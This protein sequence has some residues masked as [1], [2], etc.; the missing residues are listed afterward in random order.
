MK[1]HHVI[2]RT[3]ITLLR[4]QISDARRGVPVL[5]I[6]WQTLSY[7]AIW[8]C[9][10]LCFKGIRFALPSTICQI[11]VL[12]CCDSVIF[13]VVCMFICSI[14][15]HV[16]KHTLEVTIV[17][18]CVYV[19]VL[20]NTSGSCGYLYIYI[21]RVTILIIRYFIVSRERS[22]VSFN[23]VRVTRSLDFYV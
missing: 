9:T 23:W 18:L 14:Y 10:W 11:G 19:E 20:F 2:H 1:I 16:I 22:Y 7:N 21:F 8:G 13:F 4:Y 3:G 17:L 12:N 6:T 15:F 5:W